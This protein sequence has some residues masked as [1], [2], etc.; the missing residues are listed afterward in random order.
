[1]IINGRSKGIQIDRINGYVDHVHMLFRLKST[2]TIAEIM[3]QVK[4]ESSR[5]INKNRLTE[6]PFEWQNDYFASAVC[7]NHLEETKAYID[8]QESHHEIR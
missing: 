3:N 6:E 2:Q 4:G 8:L 1:M 7:A 5:W